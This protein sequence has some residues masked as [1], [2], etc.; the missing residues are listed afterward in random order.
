MLSAIFGTKIVLISI[1]IIPWC[2][3]VGKRQCLRHRSHSQGQDGWSPLASLVG[4]ELAGDELRWDLRHQLSP[5][6]GPSLSKHRYSC[7]MI[8]QHWGRG[9]RVPVMVCSFQRTWY[10]S[11]SWSFFTIVYAVLRDGWVRVVTHPWVW[12]SET[13][14]VEWLP[15][16]P[17]WEEIVTVAEVMEFRQG[18]SYVRNTW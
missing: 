14:I 1:Y 4:F 6:L 16:S 7:I 5:S 9:P 2:S 3:L 12:M 10:N 8:L 11:L 15:N 13:C 18:S 17:A